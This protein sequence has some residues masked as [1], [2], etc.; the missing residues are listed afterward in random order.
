VATDAAV[1]YLW[2][3]KYI[4]SP[5]LRWRNAD[6]ESADL[7]ET[8]YY[9]ADANFN[10]T[11]LV[12]GSTG[13]PTERY[14]YDAYGRV[15]V[16]NPDWSAKEQNVSNFDNNILY[17]GAP[18]D[19]E[20]GLIL[21]RR[22]YYDPSLGVFT[23]K[24]PLGLAGGNANLYGYASNNP[25]RFTDPMGLLLYSQG[26]VLVHGYDVGGERRTVVM[27]HRYEAPWY[28]PLGWIYGWQVG[29]YH[30]SVVRAY[31]ATT[32]KRGEILGYDYKVM[33]EAEV[34]LRDWLARNPKA[35]YGPP[36]TTPPP[37]GAQTIDSDS[38]TRSS[39]LINE[40]AALLGVGDPWLKALTLNRPL[41]TRGVD[42]VT[43]AMQK[44]DPDPD[45]DME[46]IEQERALQVMHPG[47]YTTK[48]WRHAANKA[49]NNATAADIRSSRASALTQFGPGVLNGFFEF[50]AGM[51]EVSV[52]RWELNGDKGF[53]MRR[54]DQET[55]K[56][57][58]MLWQTRTWFVGDELEQGQVVEPGA[59]SVLKRWFGIDTSQIM[60]PAKE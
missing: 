27:E 5:I 13:E 44:Q 28:N 45:Y 2:D 40:I 53:I 42:S 11:A 6:L 26:D 57:K 1:Q 9:T 32:G 8:L 19:G 33:P 59:E 10:V 23:S 49:A 58:D 15:T 37:M 20:T 38:P 3:P 39:E 50:F 7:E 25:V 36:V 24:D 12:D 46:A 16:L 31:D 43:A 41:Y 22:R 21:M 56:W 4:D 18:L 60:A 34:E 30:S 52:L 47:Q 29:T 51:N 55:G 14:I 54:K 17:T 48:G 35:R